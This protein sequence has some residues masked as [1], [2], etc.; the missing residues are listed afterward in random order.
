MVTFYLFWQQLAVHQ[1]TMMINNAIEKTLK[2]LTD[3]NQIIDKLL[4]EDRLIANLMNT[5]KKGFYSLKESIKS[6]HFKNFL[7]LDNDTIDLL[8][9]H[10]YSELACIESSNKSLK[11]KYK[12]VLKEYFKKTT[13]IQ[14]N[15]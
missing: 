7:K 3:L 15:S 2:D 10:I 13:L 1:K 4:L 11:S 9:M 12:R 6:D 5:Q 8:L 14:V